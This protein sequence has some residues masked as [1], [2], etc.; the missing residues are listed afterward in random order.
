MTRDW[1]Y[2]VESLEMINLSF[3]KKDNCGNAKIGPWWKIGP[4]ARSD[5]GR[6]ARSSSK[7][8]PLSCT[9]MLLV[10][11][12][13]GSPPYM[14]TLKNK[15]AEC[16]NGPL[17]GCGSPGQLSPND[18][19]PSPPIGQTRAM[20]V[21]LSCSDCQWDEQIWQLQKWTDRQFFKVSIGLMTLW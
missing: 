16:R 9:I 12:L 17:Q 3:Q 15:T 8:T 4:P 21:L 5:L 1:F 18:K 6:P 14:K 7:H 11:L 10:S 20:F 13:R 2:P 19:Q